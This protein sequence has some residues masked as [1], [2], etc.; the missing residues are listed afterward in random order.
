[1]SVK[2]GPKPKLLPDD[3]IREYVS[4]GLG[5]ITISRKLKKEKGI[6]VS[7]KTIQRRINEMVRVLN[8]VLKEK[9]ELILNIEDERKQ[10]FKEHMKLIDKYNQL[11]SQLS[12]GGHY[13]I[14]KEHCSLVPRRHDKH[15]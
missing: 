2:P 6:I 12:G 9:N 8:I 11:A 3:L 5:S 15:S 13:T 1:M 10:L 7:Y 4:N 14:D